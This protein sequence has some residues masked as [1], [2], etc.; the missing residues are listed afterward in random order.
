MKRFAFLLL[1]SLAPTINAGPK[2]RLSL[3]DG[4]T[5][6]A[7]LVT[8]SIVVSTPYGDLTIPA[9]DIRAIH[10]SQHYAPGEEAAISAAIK[11]LG[12]MTHKER[13]RASEALL[14]H[15]RRSL[16]ILGIALKSSDLEAAKRAEYAKEKILAS[17]PEAADVPA[18]DLID[19]VQGPV[20]GKIKLEALEVQS[21]ILGKNSILLANVRQVAAVGNGLGTFRLDAFA[22]GES[23]LDTG[24]SIDD[25]GGASKIHIRATGQ[26]DL[27]P[28]G[29]GQYIATP[30]GYNT[31]GKG[32]QFMAGALVARIGPHGQPF[33]LGEQSTISRRERGNLFLQIVPS[34]WNNASAGFYD[35]TVRVAD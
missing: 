28:Q 31:A 13:E 9:A 19:T 15:G 7:E 14:K 3:D 2:I 33:F 20:R 26:I 30:K 24:I 17:D 27:W 29:P 32:G 25:W 18:V 23:W 34:P 10:L 6:R 4:S 12:S 11:A 22:H 16:P 5:L 8:S 1:L 35:V 21:P